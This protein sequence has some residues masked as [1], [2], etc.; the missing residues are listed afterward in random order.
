MCRHDPEKRL[1]ESFFAL[2]KWVVTPN[3]GFSPPGMTSFGCEQ[4][5]PND[6]CLSDGGIWQL[7]GLC[8]VSAA[9]DCL[10][11]CSKRFSLGS[12]GQGVRDAGFEPATSCV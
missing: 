11:L 1:F 2:V 10:R 8:T 3:A 9:A 12:L 5:A 7:S 4:R 6:A